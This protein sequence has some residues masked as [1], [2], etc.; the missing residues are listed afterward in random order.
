MNPE[1][2]PAERNSAA[3]SNVPHVVKFLRPE[4][5]RLWD[6]AGAKQSLAASK[7]SLKE[8]QG[9]TE[10]AESERPGYNGPIF[11]EKGGLWLRPG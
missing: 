10:I 11:S 5:S 6:A 9:N 1:A 7:L 3:A 4:S 8:P 2:S